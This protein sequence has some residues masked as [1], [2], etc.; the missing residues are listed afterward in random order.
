MGGACFPKDTKALYW[1]ANY[2]DYEI[3]II[4]ETIEVNKN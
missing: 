2:S 4:K 3:K 1:L